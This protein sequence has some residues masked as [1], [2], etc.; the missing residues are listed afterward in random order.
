M[1]V[2]LFLSDPLVDFC[3]LP[4][5]QYLF[6]TAIG[7]VSSLTP[8]QVFERAVRGIADVQNQYTVLPLARALTSS[9]DSSSSG[10]GQGAGGRVLLGG[11][12]GTAGS[13]LGQ[14]GFQTLSA[15]NMLDHG[16]LVNYGGTRFLPMQSVLLSLL[17]MSTGVGTCLDCT[18][19]CTAHFCGHVTVC[20]ADFLSTASLYDIQRPYTVEQCCH[21]PD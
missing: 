2:R 12:P 14:G 13:A 1:S 16:H 9:S 7:D 3:V 18:G 11:I 19:Y 10:G 21:S 15:M 17:A 6:G 5:A 20:C 8:A 4:L